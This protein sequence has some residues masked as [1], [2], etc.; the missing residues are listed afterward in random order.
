MKKWIGFSILVFVMFAVASYAEVIGKSN[1]KGLVFKDKLEV[2]AFDDPFIKGV[3]CYTTYYDRALTWNDSS[4]V[5]LSC[6]KTGPISGKLESRNHI[7]AQS[8]NFF[9]K[10][11]VVDRYYDSKRKVLVYVTYTKATSG[12]NASNSIS[13]VVVN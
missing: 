5:S 4:S 9:F 3:T 13:V 7:F 6:R 10:E 11:T 2:H 12:E 8:K 1:A